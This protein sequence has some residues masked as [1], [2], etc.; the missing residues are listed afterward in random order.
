MPCARVRAIAEA[1]T[2]ANV[3]DTRAALLALASRRK[4]HSMRTSKR[5]L[6]ELNE[7]MRW[8]LIEF[9]KHKAETPDSPLV[10]YL[11]QRLGRQ[12]Q[13]IHRLRRK[14]KGLRGDTQMDGDKSRWWKQE[15]NEIQRKAALIGGRIWRVQNPRPCVLVMRSTDGAL[16]EIA[17]DFKDDFDTSKVRNGEA[18]CIGGDGKPWAWTQH[19]PKT[20]EEQVF[21][22]R[23]DQACEEIRNRELM[24]RVKEL[25]PDAKTG[26]KIKKAAFQGA[27]AAEKERREKGKSVKANLPLLRAEYDRL[28]SEGH[29]HKGACRIVAVKYGHGGEYLRKILKRAPAK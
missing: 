25:E 3:E 10:S 23:L 26:K 16:G 12:K 24:T 18:W 9:G 17:P 20:A 19:E 8:P 27:I 1:L 4:G 7:I 22:S 6:E 11:T 29:S 13:E 14:I 5:S 21:V 15:V 2:T 28:V